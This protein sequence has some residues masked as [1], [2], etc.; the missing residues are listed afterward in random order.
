MTFDLYNNEFTEHN[1]LRSY[2]FAGG[3][4]RR[5]AIGTNDYQIPNDFI[6]GVVIS[7]T[8]NPTVVHPD[9]FFLQ[10]L[11]AYPHGYTLTIAYR[12]FEENTG[13][14]T[15]ISVA[16]ATLLI[17]DFENRFTVIPLVP[18]S[19]FYGI[20]GHITI[21]G[22]TNIQSMLSGE[23]LFD[24]ESTQ[25]D[26][27]VVR[28]IPRCI[29]NITI[30]NADETAFPTVYGEVEL[31]AGKN[32][33]FTQTVDNDTTRIVI[34]VEREY[35]SVEPGS[36]I[37]SL[38]GIKPNINGNFDIVSGSECLEV[39]D[40]LNRIELSETCCTP[41]CDCDELVSLKDIINTSAL[42]ISNIQQYQQT[43]SHQ[44]SLLESAL[45]VTGVGDVTQAQQITPDE[46][47]SS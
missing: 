6:V 10:R 17:T 46:G 1:A 25:F 31:A 42:A 35:P 20:Q 9:R 47:A 18:L 2:P 8:A 11:S 12:Q 19:D 26:T 29:S 5:P 40:G 3:T 36:P 15:D 45:G 24:L 16:R 30:I 14:F 22:I 34:N 37:Y 39:T 7:V 28:F 32:V 23:W 21:G 13:N 27:D 33:R 4:S 38:N 44:L 43:L 41:C